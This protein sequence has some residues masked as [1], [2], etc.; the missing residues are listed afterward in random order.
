MS[1]DAGGYRKV[2][3]KARRGRSRPPKSHGGHRK[4]RAIKDPVS[5]AKAVAHRRR[6]AEAR[7][8]SD[9]GT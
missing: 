2:G 8:T 4:A 3:K 1:T 5:R 7:S 9:A 6:K